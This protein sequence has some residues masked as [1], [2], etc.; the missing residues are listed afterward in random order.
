MVLGCNA[1]VGVWFHNRLS[2]SVQ[3]AVFGEDFHGDG[4]AVCR[5]HYGF[6]RTRDGIT[7]GYRRNSEGKTVAYVKDES[8]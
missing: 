8:F 5:R 6:L 7:L 2:P 3:A 1:R 4:L